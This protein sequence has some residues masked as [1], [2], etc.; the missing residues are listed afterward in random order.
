MTYSLIRMSGIS[1]NGY[2]I[3]TI[4][5][6]LFFMDNKQLAALYFEVDNTFIQI[7]KEQKKSKITLNYFKDGIFHQ[8]YIQL[9]LDEFLSIINDNRLW[10][11]G[12]KIKSYNLN[13]L[14]TMYK[15]FIVNYIKDQTPF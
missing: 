7:D 11:N 9:Q 10:V 12:N 3:M 15:K 13:M 4:K 14:Q 1:S 2:F 5:A 6:G 8:E